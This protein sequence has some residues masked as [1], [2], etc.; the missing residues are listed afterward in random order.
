VGL[1]LGKRSLR[2]GMCLSR[3]SFLVKLFPQYVQKSIF[4]LGADLDYPPESHAI[5]CALSFWCCGSKRILVS[6]GDFRNKA[7]RQE[8]GEIKSLWM[9]LGFVKHSLLRKGKRVE[10]ELDMLTP[11]RWI[12]AQ[13]YDPRLS[14]TNPPTL[15]KHEEAQCGRE[16]RVQYRSPWRSAPIPSS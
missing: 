3:C 8:S 4:L 6:I 10:H 7:G 2:R 1:R 9:K 14:K 11:K 15:C 13:H 5:T 16:T 12:T